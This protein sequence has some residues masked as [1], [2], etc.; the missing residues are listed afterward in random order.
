MKNIT[1]NGHRLCLYEDIDELPI[2]NYQKYNKF[3]L[4][5]TGIGSDIDA[6]DQHIVRLA[7]FMRTDPKR[8][9]QE[10]KNLRQSMF[11]INSE[12]SPKN[13]SF[14]ALIKSIDGVEVTDHSD[15]N[16]KSIM[17]KINHTRQSFISKLVEQIKK[18]VH[19]ELEAY[20]PSFFGLDSSSKEVYN[21]MKK[22]T[23]LRLDTIQN[24][25]DHDAECEEILNQILDKYKPKSYDGPN[26][27]EIEFDKTFESSCFLISQKSGAD[28][29]SMTVMQYYNA[30]ENIKKQSDAEAKAY[31]R[32]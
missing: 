11:M 22:R 27:V 18:K 3:M 26:S 9:S 19:A 30:L 2:I 6:I 13:M 10:L 14:A 5:D 23:Q 17:A 20:F 15:E 31:K 25:T 1:L 7:R 32:K 28:P 16:L 21:L 4:F 29:K 24:G 8:A 12:I